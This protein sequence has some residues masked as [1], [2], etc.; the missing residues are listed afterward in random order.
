MELDIDLLLNTIRD[1][2]KAGILDSSLLMV[3]T[4]DSQ[5]FHKLLE[6]VE[7]LDT[8]EQKIKGDCQ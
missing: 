6:A 1:G 7:A 8:L 3:K 5:D 4:G 2:L